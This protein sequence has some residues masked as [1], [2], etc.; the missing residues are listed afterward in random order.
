VDEL[1]LLPL[2]ALLSDTEELLEDETLL[3]DE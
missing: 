1:L 3:N 2:D